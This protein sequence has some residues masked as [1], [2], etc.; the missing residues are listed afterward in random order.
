[1]QSVHGSPAAQ[2]MP[3]YCAPGEVGERARSRADEAPRG[4]RRQGQA[5]PDAQT[6]SG[7]KGRGVSRE[8]EGAREGDGA[9]RAKRH[10][11]RE[12][13]GC[14]SGLRARTDREPPRA[15]PA[16]RS[17]LQ[18]Q[19]ARVCSASVQ[20]ELSHLS[21][22]HAANALAPS[23]AAVDVWRELLVRAH[24]RELHHVRR[25]LAPC[26]PGEVG[27]KDGAQAR[28]EAPKEA[29]ANHADA[30]HG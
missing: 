24:L 26:I 21:P 13:G 5:C 11:T 18:A 4:S 6:A 29:L 15:T 12:A 20:V 8:R 27:A 9:M 10:G 2:S 30:P 3:S 28:G 22:R 16:T 25:V 1:M 23:V 7:S 19:H 14:R 17:P